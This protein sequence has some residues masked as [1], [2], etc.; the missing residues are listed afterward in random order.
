MEIDSLPTTNTPVL[1]RSD[2][3]RSRSLAA[4]L[5]QP[6]TRELGRALLY[7]SPALIIFFLFT[8]FPFF[9]AIYLSLHIT[10]SAGDTVRFNGVDYYLRVLGLDGSGRT[11]Y[12]NSIGTSFLFVLM[13]VPATIVVSV[14]LALLATAR[15][16]GIQ[17]FRTVFTS[18]VAISL[19]S[20]GIIWSL[21]YSPSTKATQWVIDLLGIQATSLLNNN[22]TALPA[23]AV[24]TIW[25]GLG[26]S[27]II[28][29][30]GIQNIPQDLYE[31]AAIDGA[32]RVQSF[33]FI[34]LPLLSPTLFFLGVVGTI[35]N[36]QAFTQFHLLI[37]DAPNTVF[38][39]ETYRAFW[40]DNRYGLASAMSI[41]IFVILLTL[42]I[43]QYRVLN[44]RV[45]Y[46]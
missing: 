2:R 27:F 8:Y 19:A 32:N 25:A 37:P 10:D 14:G 41:I 3:P 1:T 39:Y 20:G 17:V 35:G 16:K 34:T 18:S 30:A 22:L 46:Q 45:F 42:T 9:R 38:V 44:R 36:I 43:V 31:S 24:M 23:V 11:D 29:L 12:L 28:A 5:Q 15:V 33:R 21:L 40:Y 13:V 26:F 4:W 6:S 7:S